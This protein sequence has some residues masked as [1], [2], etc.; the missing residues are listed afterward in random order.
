MVS[1]VSRLLLSAVFINYDPFCCFVSG[2]GLPPVIARTIRGG[3][4]T[5]GRS[6]CPGLKSGKRLS[7]QKLPGQKEESYASPSPSARA[8]RNGRDGGF[9]PTGFASFPRPAV[10][11]K[12]GPSGPTEAF[13]WLGR[14]GTPPGAPGADRGLTGAQPG[15]SRSQGFL[16]HRRHPRHREE[17]RT[18]PPTGGRCCGGS[19]S[20]L[21]GPP[22]RT[23]TASSAVSAPWR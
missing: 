9:L 12:T 2:S 10:S 22:G 19:Q 8:A 14:G 18:P 15:F 1:V 16:R 17:C 13:S 6:A 3:R 20:A 23:A 11:P 7:F 4:R 5:A 21:P